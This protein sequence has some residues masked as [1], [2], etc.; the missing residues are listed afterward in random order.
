[1]SNKRTLFQKHDG[2]GKTK[3]TDP[4]LAFDDVLPLTPQ[5]CGPC[6][7]SGNCSSWLV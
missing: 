7:L 5:L 2:E 3:T 1:M 6:R 4:F